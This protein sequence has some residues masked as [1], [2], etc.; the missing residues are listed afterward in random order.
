MIGQESAH[1]TGNAPEPEQIITNLR[2]AARKFDTFE[3]NGRTDYILL[4]NMFLL[5]APE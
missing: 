2:N 4:V 3:N 5:Q 1:C